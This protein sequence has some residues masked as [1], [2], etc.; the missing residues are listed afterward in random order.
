MKRGLFTIL[1]LS[2]MLFTSTAQERDLYIEIISKKDTLAKDEIFTVVASIMNV[3][4]KEQRICSWSCSYDENWQL[5]DSSEKFQLYRPNCEKNI[6]SCV[7]LQ[8]FQRCE[9]ELYLQV[10]S[11]AKKGKASFRLGFIPCV[12]REECFETAKENQK[13]FWSQE[14]T[15]KIK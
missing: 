6:V 9:K 4:Q 3:T 13:I 14:V 5:K 1:F 7:T 2:L 11:M 8:P 12:S 15:V 10:G